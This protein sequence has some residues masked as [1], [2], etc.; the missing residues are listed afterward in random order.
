M[1]QMEVFIPRSCA[2]AIGIISSGGSGTWMEENEEV[3][4]GRGSGREVRPMAEGQTLQP[5]AWEFAVHG[6]SQVVCW[7]PTVLDIPAHP[8]AQLCGMLEFARRRERLRVLER[9][10]QGEIY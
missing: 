6:V 9:N 3:G 2:I 4:E 7:Q 8:L 5:S 10:N 1:G